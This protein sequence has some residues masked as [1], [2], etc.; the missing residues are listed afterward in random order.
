MPID[1]SALG[2][3]PDLIDNSLFALSC[4]LKDSLRN[5]SDWPVYIAQDELFGINLQRQKLHL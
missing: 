5:D 1:S 4:R 3:A 2:P